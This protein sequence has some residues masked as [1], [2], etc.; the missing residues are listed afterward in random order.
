MPLINSI[1]SQLMRDRISQIDYF[2]HRPHEVQEEWFT[3]LINAG[4][5][6]EWGRKYGYDDIKNPEQYKARIPINE[7]HDL[8]PYIERL[9]KGE[10]KLL[11]NTKISWFAKSSGTTSDKSKYIPLSRESIQDC[12]FKGGKDLLSIYCNENPETQMFSGK[13]LAMGGSLKYTRLKDHK[14]GVGDLSAVIIKNLPVWA[15]YIR[16]PRRKIALHH[17][18]EEKI[19]EMAMSGLTHKVTSLSGVP[20]WT[21]LLVKRVLEIAGKESIPEVWPDME[22]FFHGGVNFNPYR[23]QYKKLFPS[24]DMQYFETY[25]ASEG[26]IAMQ[27]RAG[28]DDMLLML[29]Y[30]IFYEFLPMDQI[31]TENPRTINLDEVETETNYALVISTNGGLWRYLIGDTIKFTSLKPYR[32]KVTGR[33]RNFINAVGE[34]LI[35]DNAENALAIACRENDAIVSEYTAAP[36]YFTSEDNAAHEWLIEF[37]KAPGN[38]DKFTDSLDGALQS[39]NSDYE[40]KRYNNMVLR[41]PIVHEVPSKTFYNWLKEKGKL[42]G[43]NKVP[44]LSNERKFVDDILKMINR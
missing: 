30:G 28:A 4:R 14:Y 44:R 10:H 23:E 35:V 9:M 3:R 31:N 25:N 17:K 19:E 39:L 40:A 2:M 34:E 18:W 32:I 24:P 37:D 33:T 27:D 38:L 29:D 13:G 41:K 5:D 20:S 43:Q 1:I 16:I 15:E 42:G 36:V 8:Q 12:H 7:Y 11:W 26:Y 21:L 6:T 22:V